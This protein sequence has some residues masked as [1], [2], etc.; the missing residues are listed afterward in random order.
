MSDCGEGFGQ[1]IEREQGLQ[2]ALSAARMTMIA[3]GGAIGTGLFLAIGFAINLAGPA[4]LVSYA[5]GAVIALLLMGCLAEMHI[6][7]RMMFSLARAG[8]AP[9]P[10]GTLNARGVPI[11]GCCCRASASASRRC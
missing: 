11:R 10:F 5:I 8:Y 4:V 3:I 1:I 9:A 2:R 7:T 6:T